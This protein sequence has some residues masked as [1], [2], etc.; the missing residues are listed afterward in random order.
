M[1]KRWWM[2]FATSAVV[3]LGGWVAA[4]TPHG[5]H[6]CQCK[7]DCQCCPSDDCGCEK[8]GFTAIVEQAPADVPLELKGDVVVVKVDKVIVVKEDRTVVRSLPFSVVAPAGGLLYSWDYPSTWA[9]RRK[10]NVL[11]VTSAPKGSA[12]VSVEWPVVDFKAQTTSI[13]TGSVSFDVG[14]VTPKPD[15]NPKPDPIPV[16]AGFRV[17]FV[18]ES[19]AKM[20]A[21]QGHIWNSTAIAAY[22]NSH[23]AKDGTQPGWRKFDKDQSADLDAAPIKQLWTDS[24][25]Q[26][27]AAM[28]S[29]VIAVGQT[30][31]VYPLPATEAETLALLKSKGGA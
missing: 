25:A 23:C 29:L 21:E 24:K 26:A 1:I 28:P 9:A 10:A 5:A 19:S 3:V 8:W 20:T 4:T 30:A 11:E 22:L 13:K 15:P 18:R 2:A 27:V 12:T 7:P 14:D 16:P 17:L 31:T 6:V